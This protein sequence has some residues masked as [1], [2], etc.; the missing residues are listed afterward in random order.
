MDWVSKNVE[1]I[2]KLLQKIS[3][4]QDEQGKEI[5]ALKQLEETNG[6]GIKGLGKQLDQVLEYLA[7]PPAVSFTAT[8]KVTATK[9]GET[10]MAKPNTVSPAIS[11]NDNGTATITNTFYDVDGIATSAPTGVTLSY[12]DT[13]GS[14]TLTPSADTFSCVAAVIQPPPQPLAQNVTFGV[15][16]ASGLV[17]QTAPITVQTDPPLNV[18]S[19]P[20]G[21]FVAAVTEP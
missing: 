4:T 20:A 16:C 18:V 8:V 6:L 19:G 15:T 10:I 13:S 14:F 11:V 7:P 21:S 2:L 1:E 5:D 9:Q 12:A 17:G 3:S